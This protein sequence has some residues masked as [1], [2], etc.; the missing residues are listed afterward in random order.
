MLSDVRH[1]PLEQDRGTLKRLGE[2]LYLEV[3][4]RD[5]KE[6]RWLKQ[7]PFLTLTMAG[8]ARDNLTGQR[9]MLGK[10]RNK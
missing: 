1:H 5:G 9:F 6:G 7:S 8:E 10:L 4:G 2:A 3:L